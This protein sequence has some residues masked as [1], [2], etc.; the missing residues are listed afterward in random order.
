MP[1]VRLYRVALSD[2]AGALTLYTPILDGRLES[3]LSSFESPIT[4]HT[5][6]DV[7]VRTLDSFAFRDIS[8]I[9]IDVE[10]HESAVLRGALESLRRDRPMLLVEIEERHRRTPVG[11]VFEFLRR[12]GYRAYFRD[13]Q[14]RTRPISE[15]DIALH[16]RA[17]RHDV[18]DRRYINNFLFLHDQDHRSHRIG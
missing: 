18:M 1:N 8:F 13:A 17:W 14:H 10:G 12:E 15:Y 9:K 16:Q 4:P 7:E 3:G 5:R 6:V 11:E 2:S